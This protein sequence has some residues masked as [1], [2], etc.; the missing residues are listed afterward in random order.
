MLM[1]RYFW[2]WLGV[3]SLLMIAPGNLLFAGEEP[4]SDNIDWDRIPPDAHPG[5]SRWIDLIHAE[6][7]KRIV[8]TSERFDAF[9]GDE[10][11]KEEQQATQLHV[12]TSV[13][14]VEGEGMAWTW[15][16]ELNLSLPRL[17]NKFQV[18]VDTLFQEQNKEG[19]VTEETAAG[20][21]ARN[22][23]QVRIRYN[24][25]HRALEWIS[26]DGGVKMN[27]DRVKW[28]ALEPFG[29]LRFRRTSDFDPWA[30]RFTQL[31]N[32][33]RSEGFN[34]TTRFDL[35]RRF[36]THTLVRLSGKTLYAQNMKG[37][38]LEHTFSFRRQFSHNQALG[39][40]LSAVSFTSPAVMVDRYTT[41]LTYRRR[42]YRAWVFLSINPQAE[43]ERAEHFKLAPSLTCDLEIIFGGQRR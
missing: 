16:V 8:N 41:S 24:A 28:E 5:I 21:P 26:V 12:T 33:F 6:I 43:F 35:E 20:E 27:K 23:V 40:E 30:L 1:N 37:V 13:K 39:I 9:F 2:T 19:I 15:P 11:I 22:E 29:A 31:V 32:W 36:R 10:R 25:L 34:A 3:V 38:H 17:N 7:S 18:M 42:I 4:V 14:L